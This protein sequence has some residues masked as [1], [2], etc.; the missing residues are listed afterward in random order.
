MSVEHAALMEAFPGVL[1][2]PAIKGSSGSTVYRL[3]LTW[4]DAERTFSFAELV[5]PRGF[6]EH[7]IA[8]IRLSP[9]AVLRAPHVEGD[10]R[11]CMEGDPG[12]GRGL[13]GTQR[14][15][16][17]LSRFYNEFVAPWVAGQLDWDFFK[18]P[19]NYW[20][21]NVA[22]HRTND[23]T[24]RVIWTVDDVPKKARVREGLLLLPKR[25]I[26]A[27]DG[28]DPFVQRII[29][30][31]GQHAKQRVRVL[32][33]DIPISHS[34]VPQTWP[35]ST[36]ALLRVLR[37]RL[38]PADYCRFFEKGLRRRRL[39]EHRVAILRNN[40]GGFAF[41]LPGGPPVINQAANRHRARPARSSLQPLMVDRVDPQWTVGRDQ[42]SSVRARQGTRVVVFGAGALG[43]PVVEQLAK[44]GVGHITLVDSDSLEAANVGRHLLGIQHVDYG[45]A[46]AV[47]GSVTRSHPS[48]IV[49]AYNG[50]AE[51]WLQANTLE[52][53]N[54]VLD[55]TG[56]PEVRWQL[57]EARRKF[58]CALVVGWM[59]PFVT[60]AHVCLLTRD[61]LWFSDHADTNDRLNSLEAVD[62]PPEVIRQ[63]PGCSSRFQAYTS[64]NAAYAV[65]LVSENALLAIDG[66]FET[67]KVVSMVRGR[68]FLDKQ[69]PGLVFRDWASEA[70]QHVAVTMERPFV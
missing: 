67:S 50:S 28:D 26:M 23:D 66:E 15:Q 27:G 52:D 5:L 9:D 36:E 37:S 59:E 35:R 17:L 24:A 3:N 40:E 64:A 18:E 45:K 16:T 43:S 63:V 53:I 7:G 41:V 56:E 58:P 44:A 54:T 19:Q 22:Q 39:R 12:P 68:R 62:W 14:V 60:A 29:A 13:G 42:V 1:V 25:L 46:E 8:R 70:E 51:E 21:V 34:L 31:L 20:A 55:L 47:A 10:G 4:L 69:W 6:P 38:T 57:N 48:C 33:A 32:I 2:G 61:R 11:L 49:T 65:A 30:A